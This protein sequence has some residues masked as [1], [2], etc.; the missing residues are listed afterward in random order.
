VTLKLSVGGP[1]TADIMIFGA[2]PCSPGRMKCRNV[3]YLGLLPAPVGGLSDITRLYYAV[4]GAPPVGWRVFIRTQQQVNGWESGATDTSAG[5][6]AQRP[7]RPNCG[8]TC[9][10]DAQRR[11][12]G[13]SKDAPGNSWL[14]PP[15]LL[16]RSAAAALGVLVDQKRPSP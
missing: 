13:C 4:Y 7:L 16:R 14:I 15:C 12:K 3:T 6:K 8:L 11:Y 9:T 2:A 5:G 1:V 10:K